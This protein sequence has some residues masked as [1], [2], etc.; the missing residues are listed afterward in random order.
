M[1]LFIPK[2]TLNDTDEFDEREDD[3]I[4]TATSAVTK[5]DFRLRVVLGHTQGL[6]KKTLLLTFSYYFTH[7]YP[8]I[9][10]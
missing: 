3:L 7:Y 8:Q 9:L 6:Q 4:V 10:S 5:K 1:I 2:T